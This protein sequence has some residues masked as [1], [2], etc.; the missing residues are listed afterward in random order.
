MATSTLDGFP[1][2]ADKLAKAVSRLATRS[3]KELGLDVQDSVVVA[4]PVD[5][6]KLRSNWLMSVNVPRTDV[7]APYFP[8][9]RLGRDEQ[10]NRLAAASQGEAAVQGLVEQADQQLWIANN[11]PYVETTNR[12]GTLTTSAGY[13]RRGIDAGIARFKKRNKK[14]RQ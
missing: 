13:V 7:I 2:R 6:G 12:E 5:T 3:Q 8:G 14:A 11:T 10:G 1:V 9:R 4:T